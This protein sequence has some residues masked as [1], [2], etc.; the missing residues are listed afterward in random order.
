MRSAIQTGEPIYVSSVSMV[1]IA[2]LTEKKRLP[3][4]NI[5]YSEQDEGYIADLPDLKLFLKLMRFLMFGRY[6]NK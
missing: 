1:E 2:Y 6:R 5:F 3:K 4:E